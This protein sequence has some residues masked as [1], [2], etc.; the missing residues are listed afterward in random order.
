METRTI[1]IRELV[2]ILKLQKKGTF[3]HFVIHTT[4]KMRKTNNPYFDKVTKVTEGNIYLGGNYETRVK[5]NTGIGDFTPEH[6][7]VGEHIG[8]GMCILENTKLG[9]FYLQYEWFDEVRPKSQYIFNG[10]PIEKGLFEGFM[11][12]YTPNQYGVNVQSVNV[13]NIKELTLNKVKYI[14]TDPIP[15][16][17]MVITT[18]VNG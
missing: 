18:E 17:P 13:N 9:R 1:T 5:N 10:D 14:T 8:E 4:P 2:E 11:N 3:S 15:E 16:Q 6:N 7:R 12:N